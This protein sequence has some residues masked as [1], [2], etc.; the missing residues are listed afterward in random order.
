MD[1]IEAQNVVRKILNESDKKEFDALVE[2][3]KDP[4]IVAQEEMVEASVKLTEL[5]GRND[6]QIIAQPISGSSKMNLFVTHKGD[7]VE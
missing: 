1:K 4:S 6:I 5:F 3:M 2:A 7:I